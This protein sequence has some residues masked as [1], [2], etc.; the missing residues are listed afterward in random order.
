MIPF[1]PI[2]SAFCVNTGGFSFQRRLDTYS[3]LP[4]NLHTIE[5]QAQVR[6]N[7]RRAVD[8]RSSWE[9][10]GISALSQQP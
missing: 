6:G 9:A 10:D 7:A 2:S 1:R 4:Y 8:S 3:I 5:Q